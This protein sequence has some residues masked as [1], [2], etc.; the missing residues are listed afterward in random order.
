MKEIYDEHIAEIDSLA[1]S[2]SVLSS[3]TSVLKSK[4]SYEVVKLDSPKNLIGISSKDL[5]EI[6]RSVLLHIIAQQK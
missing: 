1:L 6:D 3:D 4:H 5:L 2:E